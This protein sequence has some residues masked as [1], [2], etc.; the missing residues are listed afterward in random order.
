M[1]PL[2]YALG[3]WT[4]R[5]LETN[6]HDARLR[7]PPPPL[8]SSLLVLTPHPRS[9]FVQYHSYE[10]QLAACPAPTPSYRFSPTHAAD[11]LESSRSTPSPP[12]SPRLTSITAPKH[13]APRA[14]FSASVRRPGKGYVAGG[15][16]IPS[17]GSDED[18][19]ESEKED[20]GAAGRQGRL[21][22][23]RGGDKRR[24]GD[25]GRAELIL[26]SESSSQADALRPGTWAATIVG[27]IEAVT[28][29]KRRGS[30]SLPRQMRALRGRVRP[31]DAAPVREASPPLTLGESFPTAVKTCMDT[32]QSWR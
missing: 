28:P 24:A 22:P 5:C 13:R 1:L 16:A 27:S 11:N 2:P 4:T 14:S 12:S 30:P 31:P 25:G 9:R 29:S 20:D 19:S 18:S 10:L 15:S 3:W 32:M 6:Q 17:T 8:T 23:G 21:G 7:H 26:S